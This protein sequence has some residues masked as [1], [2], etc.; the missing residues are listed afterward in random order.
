M[1]PVTTVTDE[2]M[3]RWVTG[4]PTAAGTPKADDTPGTTSQA[5]PACVS[6]SRLLAAAA[7]EEGV[8]TLQAHH[9]RGA[10]AV[11]DEQAPDLLLAGAPALFGVL[12]HVDQRRRP[13]APGR[14]PPD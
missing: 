13:G 10:P 11:L 7:E 3:P 8:A 5:I 6:A 4:M 1:R 9:H 14:A 12:A 2:A